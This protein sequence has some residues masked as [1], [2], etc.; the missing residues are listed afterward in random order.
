MDSN[1]ELN[2]G[3]QTGNET[4]A[5]RPGAIHQRAAIVERAAHQH[6]QQLIALRLFFLLQR[7][8]HLRQ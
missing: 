1:S 8:C 6:L 3:R 4:S 2:A 5:E 7:L